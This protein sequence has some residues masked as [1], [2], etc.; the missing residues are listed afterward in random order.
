[1]TTQSPRSLETL[2]ARVVAAAGVWLFLVLAGVPPAAADIYRYRDENGVW[3]FTN[4]R[5]DVRYRLYIRSY[6]KMGVDY[7]PIPMLCPS[8]LHTDGRKPR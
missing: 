1:M 3:H 4:I 2:R 6:P 7:A 5:T 8:S